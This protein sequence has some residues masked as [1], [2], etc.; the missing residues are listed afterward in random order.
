MGKNFLLVVLTMPEF[1]PGEA[2]YLQGMLEAGVEKLHIRKPGATVH[3]VEDL[4]RQ[5]PGR[6]YSRLVLHG[7]AEVRALAAGLGIPQVHG[8][9]AY[10]GGR[11]MNGSRLSGGGGP[12][13]RMGGGPEVR[14]PGAIAVSTSVHSPEELDALPGGLAY[15]FLSPLFDSLSKP[16]YKGEPSLLARPEGR[17]GCKAIGLGGIG[18]A[19]IGEVLAHGWEGAAVLGWIW[20]HPAEAVDRYKRLKRIISEY[21][22]G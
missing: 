7:S 19:T 1:F 3:E 12:E 10:E 15:A 11:I 22:A 13:V 8:P 18:E 5:L 20:D 17:G 14:I 6:W 21:G 4:I 9:V 16:G 2:G